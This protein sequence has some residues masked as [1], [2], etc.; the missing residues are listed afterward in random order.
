M[1]SFSII[2]TEEKSLEMTFDL[3]DQYVDINVKKSTSIGPF[4]R[5]Y[6]KL[7]LEESRPT[8]RDYKIIIRYYKAAYGTSSMWVTSSIKVYDNKNIEMETDIPKYEDLMD[9][10]PG[11][12]HPFPWIEGQDVIPQ[13]VDV[14]VIEIRWRYSWLLKRDI[15]V[16][17]EKHSNSKQANLYL[18]ITIEDEPDNTDPKPEKSRINNRFQLSKD[19]FALLDHLKELLNNNFPKMLFKN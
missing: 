2:R 11:G 19:Y 14:D 16:P 17:I 13:R 10:E 7:Y 3:Q 4:V 18:N 15:P 9:G 8:H 1:G 5:P 12:L 6:V